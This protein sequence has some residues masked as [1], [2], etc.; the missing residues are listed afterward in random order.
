MQKANLTKSYWLK[1]SCILDH[2]MAKPI[3][4]HLLLKKKNVL[5]SKLRSKILNETD[6]ILNCDR[7]PCSFYDFE[8]KKEKKI[9]FLDD[10]MHCYWMIQDTSDITILIN[11]YIYFNLTRT[12]N[13]MEGHQILEQSCSLLVRGE[14]GGEERTDFFFSCKVSLC[15]S[16]T[17]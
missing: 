15:A 16:C 14:K 6:F 13:N 3:L 10:V 5:S 9:A 12:S 11:I 2:P 1:P 8:W 17:V 7:P 4:H